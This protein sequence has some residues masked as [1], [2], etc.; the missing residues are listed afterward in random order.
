[1]EDSLVILT[2][3]ELRQIIEIAKDS[4]KSYS[5]RSDEIM[6]VLKNRYMKKATYVTYHLGD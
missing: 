1:M 4:K 3:S 5:E 2:L 6:C